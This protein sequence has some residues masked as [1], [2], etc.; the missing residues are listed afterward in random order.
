MKPDVWFITPLSAIVAGSIAMVLQPNQRF[1]PLIGSSLGALAAAPLLSRKE[2]PPRDAWQ[3]P[4]SSTSTPDT[5]KILESVETLHTILETQSRELALLK[6]A[7]QSPPAPEHHPPRT[8]ILYDIENL[9]FVQGQR[10]DPTKV[11]ELVS[12]PNILDAIKHSVQVGEVQV[13]RAYGN[14]MNQV[15]QNLSPQLDQL[16]IERVAVY[17]R[18]R[19]QRNAADIQLAVD[20]IDIIHQHPD[21][22]TFV[23][24]SGDGGFGSIAL[25]LRDYGKTVIGCAYRGSASDS[26]QRVCHNFI[27]LDNPLI[28]NGTSPPNITNTS[29]QKSLQ[30]PIKIRPPRISQITYPKDADFTEIKNLEL[31]KILELI[32]YY[33]SDATKQKQLKQGIDFIKFFN[34]LK[35]VIPK[36]DP[37]RFGFCKPSELIGYITEQNN[38]PLCLAVD[39]SQHKIILCWRDNLPENSIVRSYEPKPI[40]TVAVYRGIFADEL[41]GDPLL[42]Y[43]G[44]WLIANKPHHISLNKAINL[45]V[46]YFKNEQ[47][48]SNRNGVKRAL[49]N[50]VKVN[51]LAKKQNPNGCTLSL[52]SQIKTMADL[53]TMTQASFRQ[54]VQER[55][56]TLGEVIDEAVFVKA[57]PFGMGL[58][59]QSNN[60]PPRNPSV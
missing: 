28:Q 57:V 56:A 39:N 11:S 22:N 44:Q 49:A 54:V 40:H 37:L 46:E 1:A 25:K 59:P 52:N 42:N 23:L 7:L 29:S 6:T 19:D 55:L 18:N 53:V 41:A 48:P 30:V 27:L 9:V 34:E 43:V 4:V 36:L 21:I 12:I 16:Q 35:Q 47:F 20:A 24:V 58:P 51:V 26:L 33:T 3:Q 2:H 38:L 31:A 8:A 32:N 13:Q 14:W 15:L 50:Y 17:G 5:Q 60:H 45:I 10:L